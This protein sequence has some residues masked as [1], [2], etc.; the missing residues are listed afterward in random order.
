MAL[1]NVDYR[2]TMFSIYS[3]T[4][5]VFQNVFWYKASG[6]AATAEDLWITFEDSIP[7]EIANVLSS[8]TT[9]VEAEVINLA[10]VTDFY[11]AGMSQA[12][13]RGANS[14]SA[15]NAWGFKYTRPQRGMNNGSKRFGALSN[16]DLVNGFPTATVAGLLAA[17]AT[18]LQ[19][20]L[21][22][23]LLTYSPCCVKTIEVPNSSGSGT[24]Y[25][26]DSL[27]ICNDVQFVRATTQNTRKR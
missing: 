12:G 24:H 22:Q 26:P 14:V 16:D 15:Y 1:T 25:E 18:T 19:T 2:L 27:F 6:T 23:G 13:L 4:S 9:I 7:G 10:D 5:E 8:D 3:E 11:A 21:V 17:L 20:P